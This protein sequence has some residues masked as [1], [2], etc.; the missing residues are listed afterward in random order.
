MRPNGTSG[1]FFHC[2]LHEARSQIHPLHLAGGVEDAVA[3]QLVEFA[4]ALIT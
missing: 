4:N 3:G 2:K 1:V